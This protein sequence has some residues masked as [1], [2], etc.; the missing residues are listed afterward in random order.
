MAMFNSIAGEFSWG[1]ELD[2]IYSIWAAAHPWT[3]AF[4]AMMVSGGAIFDSSDAC[5]SICPSM[6]ALEHG[7]FFWCTTVKDY[8]FLWILMQ[9]N[10]WGNFTVAMEWGGKE[11]CEANLNTTC[12]WDQAHVG[13]PMPLCSWAM[14]PSGTQLQLLLS[15]H[16]V[17]HQSPPH[18]Q[19]YDGQV[20][21]NGKPND[22]LVSLTNLPSIWVDDKLIPVTLSSSTRLLYMCFQPPHCRD[23]YSWLWKGCWWLVHTPKPTTPRQVHMQGYIWWDVGSCGSSEWDDS[24]SMPR[25]GKPQIRMSGHD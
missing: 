6:A 15:L 23:H 21:A 2:R 16:Q 18:P 3:A 24:P 8:L 19:V 22:T 12:Q 9:L 1:M 13:E 5:S 17:Q 7:A 20:L 11:N 4:L 25:I 14:Y 10:W